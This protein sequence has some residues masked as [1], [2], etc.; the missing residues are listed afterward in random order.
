MAK[1][2]QRYFTSLSANQKK[3]NDKEAEGDKVKKG[4]RLD[5]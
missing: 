2:I 1:L 3:D 4:Q 5:Q